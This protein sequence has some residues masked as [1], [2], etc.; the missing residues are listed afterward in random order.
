MAWRSF[1]ISYPRFTNN[2]YLL[3]KALVYT[4]EYAISILQTLKH[5]VHRTEDRAYSTMFKVV[6]G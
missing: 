3:R 6:Y 4:T 5:F 1:D 2:L